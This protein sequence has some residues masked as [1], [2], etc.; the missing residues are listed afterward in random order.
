MK[1]DLNKIDGDLGSPDENIRWQAAIALG[2]Y[3]ENDPSL[4]WPLVVKWGSSENDDVRAAI[5]TCVLEHILEYHF[6]EYFYKLSEIVQSGNI[7]FRDSLKICYKLG[8]A[9]LPHNSKS[10]DRLLNMGKNA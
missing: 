7:Y 9:K 1:L 8:Q 6:E 5:S 2:C 3:C 10:F 4:I